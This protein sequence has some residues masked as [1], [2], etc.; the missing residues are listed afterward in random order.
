MI[1]VQRI[2]EHFIKCS[3]LNNDLNIRIFKIFLRK[4]VKRRIFIDRMNN[5][6]VQSQSIDLVQL[7][8]QPVK[9]TLATPSSITSIAVETITSASVSALFL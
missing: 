3:Y 9:I 5:G 8:L 2:G 6:P 1:S 4:S 7:S